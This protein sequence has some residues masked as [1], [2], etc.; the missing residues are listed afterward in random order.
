MTE[1]AENARAVIGGNNPPDPLEETIARFGDGITEAENWLDGEPVTNAEQMKAVDALAKHVKAARKAIKEAR[2]AATGP[3]HEAWKAEVARWKPTEDDLDRIIK[4][5]A[6]IVGDYKKRL[7]AEQEAARRAAYQEAERKKR[8]A[9]AKAAAA[10]AGNIEAQRAAEA[11]KH[12]AL[13][14]AKA[15]QATKAAKV[16]GLR[17]VHRYEIEDHRKALHWIAA[18]DR[19]A[20][21]AFIEDYVAR[22]HKRAS[23]DGVRQWEEKEAF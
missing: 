20:V 16:T 11:A 13:D 5:L 3:L 19:D 22:N 4:G 1:T 17:R 10:D 6:A 21:T 18:N 8:E 7:A 14:A 2:D 23:I 15:A 9:E 12:E